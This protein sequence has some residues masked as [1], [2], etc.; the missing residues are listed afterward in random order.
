MNTETPANPKQS[1]K[2]LS[3]SQVFSLCKLL[4]A[5]YTSSG[6]FDGGFA[7]YASEKLGFTVTVGHV[8]HI[9]DDLGIP[10]NRPIAK[11]AERMTPILARIARLEAYLNDNFGAKL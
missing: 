6:K 3:R 2:M 5:E 9:R 4:E 8:W 1:R 10:P 11:K 7:A